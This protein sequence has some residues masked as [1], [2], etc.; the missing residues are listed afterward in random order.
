MEELTITSTFDITDDY[1]VD[2]LSSLKRLYF[3]NSDESVPPSDEWLPPTLQTLVVRSSKTLKSLP[4]CQNL[5]SL[6]HL[7]IENCRELTSVAGVQDLNSLKE[8]VI[9]NCPKLQLS[10]YDPLPSSLH[11][12]EV[13]G[14]KSLRSL[15]LQNVSYLEKLIIQNCRD[16]T[17]VVGV[18]NLNSLKELI[19]TNCPELQ[20]GQDES[21]PSKLQD[22]HIS[23][24][25]KLMLV[26][27]L[28]NLTSLKSLVLERC[29]LLQISP[30][31]CLPCTPWHV[32]IRNCPRLREWCKRHQFQCN[33]VLSISCPRNFC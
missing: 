20:F 3:N 21:L 1:G 26:T 9:T 15:A 2:N 10:P 33:Q 17:S 24:C 16:L 4:I 25:W 12:V 32:K 22:V 13:N 5:S 8:L 6:Q 19:I 29:P 31:E 30:D 14:W 7:I 27:G 23:D 18:Q 28:K 11:T